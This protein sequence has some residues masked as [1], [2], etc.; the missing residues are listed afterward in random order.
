MIREAYLAA[1]EPD[2]VLVASL[3]EGA[4]GEAAT[5]IGGLVS[6]P[7]AVVVHEPLPSGKRGRGLAD[8]S[9]NAWYADKL[10]HLRRADHLLAMS[11]AGGKA[12]RSALGWE[13]QRL[14]GLTP[15]AG[16]NWDA[17]AV[18]ALRALEA[19]FANRA[20]PSPAPAGKD[21]PRLAFL[22]PLPPQRSGISDYSA[23]LLPALS[24]FYEIEV[25]AHQETV[26]DAWITAN[27][28]VRDVEWFRRNADSFDQ[29]LYHFGNSEFHVHMVDLLEEIPGAIVLHDFFLSGLF[30]NFFQN[31]WPELLLENHGYQAFF[32]EHWDR[33]IRFPVNVAVLRNALG[34]IVHSEHSRQLAD[35]GMVPGRQRSGPSS[36]CC[37]S[38]LRIARSTGG[39]HGVLS[40]S[41][42]RRC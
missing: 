41:T 42:T 10:D 4:N 24:E 39:R 34:V 36:R 33:I 26:S 16:F 35:S 6:L 12:M 40:A 18:Q 29:V 11:H 37:A 8:P 27:L 20:V 1:L 5:S 15:A 22:S 25:I 21:K 32:V 31:D 3:F 28:P 2:V 17:T 13:P 23:D 7:T 38:P 9:S 14:T 19:A 30:Y